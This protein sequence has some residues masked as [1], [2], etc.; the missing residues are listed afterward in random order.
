MYPVPG[1]SQFPYRPC[2]DPSF[3]CAILNYVEGSGRVFK[4]D[5]CISTVDSLTVHV[6]FIADNVRAVASYARKK[7]N[8]IIVSLV[9]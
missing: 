6:V 7:L 8:R 9:E 5:E 1:I 3:S 2:P 4:N